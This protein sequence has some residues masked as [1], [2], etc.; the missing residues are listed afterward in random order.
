MILFYQAFSAHTRTADIFQIN[1][2]ITQP[3][4]PSTTQTKHRQLAPSQ[5]PAMG[6]Y[7][8][9]CYPD[10]ERSAASTSEYAIQRQ[11]AFTKGPISSSVSPT[12]RS[13]KNHDHSKKPSLQM[14]PDAT[15]SSKATLTQQSVSPSNNPWMFQM[16]RT[17][18]GKI[19]TEQEKAILNKWIK[20]KEGFKSTISESSETD[21]SSIN[22]QISQKTANVSIH[23]TDKEEM[24]ETLRAQEAASLCKS[25]DESSISHIP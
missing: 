24:K 9:V 3:S 2:Y 10:R 11:R 20:P 18:K 1:K 13:P 23:D 16:A 12:G 5:P 14:D 6:N 17:P 19:R 15:A 8:T 7:C 22:S 25:Q 21:G 4:N